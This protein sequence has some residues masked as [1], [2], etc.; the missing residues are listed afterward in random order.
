MNRH[1]YS[2]RP[3]NGPH[4]VHVVYGRAAT[5]AYAEGERDPNVL[6]Q[7]GYFR[8]HSFD[9]VEELNAFIMGVEEAT[10]HMESLLIDPNE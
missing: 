1:H 2:G 3:S 4:D 7:M 9:T 6:N 8:R 10:G 5:R